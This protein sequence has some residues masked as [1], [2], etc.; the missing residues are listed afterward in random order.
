MTRERAAIIKAYYLRNPCAELEH[1][2]EVFTGVNS[3]ETSN[4]LPYVL[5]R[6]FSVLEA[7]QD[8]GES[9]HQ[10]HHSGISTSTCGLRNTRRGIFPTAAEAGAEAPAQKLAEAW[11][12]RATASSYSEIMD[13]LDA[14]TTP[15]G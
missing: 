11:T 5:G 2:E 3:T 12:V 6:L 1:P 4:Y 8:G 7:I 9:R 13:K 10:Q 14:E 15:P